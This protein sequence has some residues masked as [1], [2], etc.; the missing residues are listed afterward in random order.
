MVYYA[1]KYKKIMFSVRLIHKFTFF[2]A[3][4]EFLSQIFGEEHDYTDKSICFKDDPASIF[5]EY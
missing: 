4:Y 2:T 3:H 1:Y 5:H